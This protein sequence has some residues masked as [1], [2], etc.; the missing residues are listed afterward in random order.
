MVGVF[1]GCGIDGGFVGSGLVVV[2]VWA[3]GV[4]GCGV[5]GEFVVE[6]NKKN[7]QM[8]NKKIIFK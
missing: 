1:G 8:M 7:K 2:V 5:G 3:V 6:M 4:G